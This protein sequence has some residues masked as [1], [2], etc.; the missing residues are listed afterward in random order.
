MRNRRIDRAAR[1]FRVGYIRRNGQ[2]VGANIPQFVH[3]LLQR[4]DGPRDQGEAGAVPGQALGGSAA[5]A[6]RA[7]RNE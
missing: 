2:R 4:R 1:L 6:R 3:G 5:D 7:A